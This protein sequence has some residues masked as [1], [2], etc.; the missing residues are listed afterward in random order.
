MLA[1]PPLPRTVEAALRDLASTRAATRASAI[2]DLVRHA[3]LDGELRA[4]S[5]PMIE[6]ALKNDEAPEVRAAAAVGLGDLGAGEALA[7][8][9]VAIEDPHVHVRQMALNALGEV[10]DGRAAPRLA[11]ALDDARPEVRYQAIIAY[12][13]VAT[14]PTDVNRA[15]ARACG[16][17]DDAVRYIALRIAEERIE[18]GGFAGG[19]RPSDAVLDE[20]RARVE[21]DAPHVMLAA[22]ILLAKV[23]EPL[24]SVRELILRAVRGGGIGAPGPDKED[25]REAVE[26]AGALGLEEAIPHL[27]RRAWGLGSLVRDTCAWNA[28]IALARMGHPRATAEISK[29]LE[30][31]RAETRAAAVVAA[32]R[33]RLVMAKEK[34]AGM[35]GAEGLDPQLVVEALTKLG[36]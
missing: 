5:L 16:D 2:A 15:L 1:P 3:V 21:K 34:I 6:A 27:E 23:G 19:V 9:L 33:A 12:A 36:G 25:E 14:D 35:K 20:A 13:K 8:L 24:R 4:R 10:G 31:P 26:L 11:R 28:K 29:D 17:A 30:S 7:A 18:G 32:G 22:A